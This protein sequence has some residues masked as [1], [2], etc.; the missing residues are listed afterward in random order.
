MEIIISCILSMVISIVVS[1]SL[2]YVSN[3]LHFKR[4]EKILDDY[5]L[6]ARKTKK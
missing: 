2:N 5:I 3:I 1:I 4:V 6:K